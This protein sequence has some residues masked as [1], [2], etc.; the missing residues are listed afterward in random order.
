MS[1]K[2]THMLIIYL[3][4]YATICNDIIAYVTTFLSFQIVV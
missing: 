3:G 4:Y 2:Y 1:G